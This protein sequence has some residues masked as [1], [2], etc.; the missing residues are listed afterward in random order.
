MFLRIGVC[1]EVLE[2]TKVPGIPAMQLRCCLLNL[3]VGLR[4]VEGKKLENFLQKR[5]AKNSFWTGFTEAETLT[6]DLRFKLLQLLF[7]SYNFT[8]D[9]VFPLC[10]T[11]S[12][13]FVVQ[14]ISKILSESIQIRINLES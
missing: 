14:S 13:I 10:F 6:K 9:P 2:L 7:R 4:L 8:A 12:G 1:A 3:T 11:R 5:A